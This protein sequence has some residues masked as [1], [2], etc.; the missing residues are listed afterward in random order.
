MVMAGC[1]RVGI[2]ELQL[3]PDTVVVLTVQ[4]L[5]LLFDAHIQGKGSRMPFMPTWLDTIGRTG[6]QLVVLSKSINPVV[7]IVHIVLS[8][9]IEWHGSREAVVSLYDHCPH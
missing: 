3:Q 1:A 2:I 8:S 5:P 4:C 6:G 7:L 9:S